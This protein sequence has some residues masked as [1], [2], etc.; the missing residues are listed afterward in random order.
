MPIR[1]VIADDHALVRTGLRTL[2][3]YMPDVQIVG[4]AGTGVEALKLVEQHQPNIAIVDVA[5]PELN[6]IEVTERVAEKFPHVRVLILSMHK[7]EDYARRALRA[8]AAGYL[9]K[10][11]DTAE[12]QL[13]IHAIAAGDSYLSPAIAKHLVANFARADASQPDSLERLTSRQRE[14]LQLIA[15]GHSRQTIAEKLN[16]SVKTFDGLRAELMERLEIY[17][18]AGLVRYAIQKGLVNLE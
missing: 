2:L 13:A 17:D 12:Y 4:E 6:G 10:D 9:L 1:I 18:T 5:M 15:E 7:T 8:G 16:I 14:V 11:S 3:Q